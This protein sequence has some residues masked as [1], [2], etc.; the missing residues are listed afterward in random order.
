MAKSLKGN[1]I[2]RTPL[3]GFGRVRLE[4]GRELVFDNDS[5]AKMDLPEV[6]EAVRVTLGPARLGG[7]KVVRLVRMRAPRPT[8]DAA[9][10]PGTTIPVGPKDE[11]M[12]TRHEELGE[13]IFRGG[14]GFGDLLGGDSMTNVVDDA[15]RTGQV[16]AVFLDDELAFVRIDVAPFQPGRTW[17]PRQ[18]FGSDVASFCLVGMLDVHAAAGQLG[19]I[20]TRAAAAGGSATRMDLD[21]CRLFWL[22]GE[23]A[24]VRVAV[25]PSSREVA[26]VV[27]DLEV[28]ETR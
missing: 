25:D 9:I 21:R 11:M 17:G 3:S 23:N 27:I 12:P 8:L 6:G 22:Q 7:E 5:V 13:A 20:E 14:V 10:G 19:E 26:T 15:D 1:V 4:D 24:V 2:E 18:K 28:C 16:T